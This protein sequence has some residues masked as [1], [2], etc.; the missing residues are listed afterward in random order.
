MKTA[1]L[2]EISNDF[3]KKADI[4][5][6]Q[7]GLLEDLKKFGDVQTSGAYSGN[8]MLSG[9]IDVTVIRQDPYSA[10]EVLEILKE[11]YLKSKFRSYFIKGDWDDDRK[12]N[13][14]PNG[15]YMGLKQRLDGEKWKVDIWFMSEEEFRKRQSDFLDIGKRKFSEE[16]RLV[17]LN[18]KKER[19]DHVLDIS[20]QQIYEAVL[21]GGI[22]TLEEV[23]QFLKT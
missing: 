11:L 4:L 10:E 15:H 12:G 2:L 23:K 17:I 9:D 21:N 13:E 5:L 20:S 1:N 16:E 22:R 3:K 6:S 8:V 7:T 19:N 18:L 14:F